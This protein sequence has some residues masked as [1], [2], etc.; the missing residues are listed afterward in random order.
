[1]EKRGDKR[2]LIVWGVVGCC[3]AGGALMHAHNPALYA[4]SACFFF[5]AVAPSLVPERYPF[6]QKASQMILLSG[7]ALAAVGFGYESYSSFIQRSY[8][9]SAVDAFFSV[10]SLGAGIALGKQMRHPSCPI[11]PEK[12]S[13]NRDPRPRA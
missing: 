11:D 13:N 7:T 9:V 8:L 10:A 3:L 12:S 1:M 4:A 6:L 5:N 2:A